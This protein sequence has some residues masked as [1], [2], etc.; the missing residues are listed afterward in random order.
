VRVFHGW[1]LV[2][3]AL[4]LQAASSASVFTAYSVIAT[5]LQSAFAPSRMLLMMGVTVAA[6]A[7][8][9]LA[10]TLGAAI[11]RFSLRLLML[12]G[13]VSLGSGFVLLSL[14]DSMAQ[15]LLV[16]LLPLAVG[17]VLT[18][19]LAGSALLAR[20]FT[21]RRALALSIAASGGALGGLVIPPLLQFLIDTLE[22]RTALR[23]YGVGILLVTV[24]LVTW[25][26]VSRPAERGLYP[27]GDREP[28]A[29]AIAGGHARVGS[30]LVFV[31]DA[32][33]WLIAV[34]LGLLLA[35][36]MGLLTNLLPLV[37][38]RGIAGAPGALLLSAFSA[39]NFVGKLASGVIAD[40]H[41][42]RILLAAIAVV[43]C[44]GMFGYERSHGYLAL[45]AFS[46]VLGLAQG[47]AVPLW[48]II[49][50]RVYGPDN[51]GRSM[52]LTSLFIMPFTLVAPPLFGR[53]YDVTGSYDTALLGC[54]VLLACVL[55]LVA[56]IRPHGRAHDARPSGG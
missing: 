17:C 32:N 27:D 11:D 12:C 54:V 50:A 29:E 8:G 30:M 33:F 19:P 1:W 37:G 42:Y 15:V 18:G 31:R 43:L 48:S 51:M 23:L 13:V 38:E 6:L 39:A 55:P 41:D 3:T 10:P 20:W 4:V 26:V 46:V 35:C 7:S 45:G 56:M 40:R 5:P 14:V 9:T 44:F 52:G 2:A 34:S 24:P 25:V 47:A 53:V 28:P 16:Y 21:R 22:W 49:L 36:P